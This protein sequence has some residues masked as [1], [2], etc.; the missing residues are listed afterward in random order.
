M[1]LSV[2]FL[3]GVVVL[4]GRITA[5]AGDSATGPG[6]ASVVVERGESLWQIATA[7]AP[8]SDPRDVVT[9]IR[10]LNGLGDSTVAAGQSIV[11]PI[12]GTAS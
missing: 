10:E 3:L 1:L 4:S 5:Q 12:Y 9:V 8:D 6:T 7:I 11:V 2:A